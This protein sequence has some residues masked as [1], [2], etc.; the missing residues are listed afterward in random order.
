MSERVSERRRPGRQQTWT[1]I[2]IAVC[3][4]VRKVSREPLFQ[5]RGA[6]INKGVHSREEKGKE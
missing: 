4:C 2:A 3:V 5:D 1:R 6:Y